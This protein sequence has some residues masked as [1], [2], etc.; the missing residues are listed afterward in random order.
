MMRTMIVVCAVVVVA[1]SLFISQYLSAAPGTLNPPA[2][3]VGGTGRTLEQIYDKLEDVQAAVNAIPGGTTGTT[4][5]PWSTVT[6]KPSSN[7]PTPQEVIPGRLHLHAI[8]YF[9]VNLELFDGESAQAIAWLKFAGGATQTTQY[10]Q[11]IELDVVV[12]N[13]LRIANTANINNV[14]AYTVLY[15]PLD[16]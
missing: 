4:S 16:P 7:N 12:E 6:F 11:K 15:R 2:G 14:S 10:S 8:I 9:N 13:G 3:P 1:S 5:G